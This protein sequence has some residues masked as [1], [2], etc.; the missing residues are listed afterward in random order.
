MKVVITS[1]RKLQLVLVSLMVSSV[2]CLLVLYR[3]R[4]P[5]KLT[6]YDFFRDDNR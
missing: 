3:R 2:L 4:R 6:D 1:K 5:E